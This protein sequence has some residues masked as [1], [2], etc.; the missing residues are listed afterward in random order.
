MLFVGVQ[1]PAFLVPWLL[2][3]QLVAHQAPSGE[4]CL[5]E[6]EAALTEALFEVKTLR[7]QVG[8]VRAGEEEQEEEELSRVG[9]P[10]GGAT[11]LSIPEGLT[12]LCQSCNVPDDGVARAR[13]WCSE[14]GTQSIAEVLQRG[15]EKDLIEA[16]GLPVLLATSLRKELQRMR[17]EMEADEECA[18]VAGT[19]PGDKFEMVTIS[20]AP[21]SEGTQGVESII[22]ITI[23]QRMEWE[24]M[25]L[26]ILIRE[27]AQSGSKQD[28][29]NLHYILHGVAQENLP[30]HILDDYKKGTYHGGPIY[31]GEYD[32]G[33]QGMTFKDFMEHEKVKISKLT[34]PEVCAIRLYTTGTYRLFNGPLRQ[35]QRPHPLAMTVFFL[36]KGLKKLR[37]AAAL[38]A[39]FPHELT[40]WRG[41]KNARVRDI[42]ES[43]GGIELA[44]TSTS[45]SMEIAIR[46]STSIKPLLFKYVATG[47]EKGV[48]INFLSVYPKEKEVLYPPGTYLRPRGSYKSGGK[49][50]VVVEP[51]IP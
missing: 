19:A 4:T 44:A 3:A 12:E 28:N 21:A 30:E 17:N 18:G 35:K 46:Y 51:Q 32:E 22:G 23:K 39:D 47:M 41:M 6:S 2:V 37:T 15:M 7:A 45:E 26:D 33:H 24:P 20:F 34:P 16:M 13:S 1:R 36:V 50:I 29:A 25:G 9:Q 11:D 5:A 38:E 27:M 40:L 8:A 14:M 10:A 42:F 31:P 49:H 43:R 48:G